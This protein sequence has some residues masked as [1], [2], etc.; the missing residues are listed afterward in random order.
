[1]RH[2][3][4]SLC[5]GGVWSAGWVAS[6]LLGGVKTAAHGCPKNVEKRNKHT[7]QNCATSWIYLQDFTS[8]LLQNRQIIDSSGYHYRFRM[9]Q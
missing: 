8:Y 3:Y 7:K 2:K 1:M 4:L 5:V 6:G 9:L